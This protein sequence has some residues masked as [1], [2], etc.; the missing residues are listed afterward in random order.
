[1]ALSTTLTNFAAELATELAAGRPARIS[2]GSKGEAFSWLNGM[3]TTLANYVNTGQV[4]GM[5]TDVVIVEPSATPAAKVAEGTEK[6]LAVK[7][8]P[9]TVTLSKFAGYAEWT[10]EAQ[11]S[12]NALANVVANVI[13]AQCLQALE[14][15]C[16]AALDTAGTAGDPVSGA[17]LQAA[18]IA[19][20]AQVLSNGGRPSIVVLGTDGYADLV[21][22]GSTGFVVDPTAGPI[23]TW[24]GSVVH[25]SPSVAAG[26]AY[27][28]DSNAMFIAENEL[29]PIGIISPY[30]QARSNK[31]ELVVD[32][33]AAPVVVAPALVVKATKTAA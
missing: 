22:L 10:L 4:T 31:V 25:V 9:K 21:S 32:I 27:V 5:T 19:A 15:D 3:P 26:T 8:T 16:V 28:L 18:V 17:T 33:L 6:P 7:F 2:L 24:L 29:S 14:T 23:G 1:M 13:A 11:L 30:N 20:Q 12:T